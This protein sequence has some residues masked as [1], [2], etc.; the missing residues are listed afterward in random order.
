MTDVWS[1]G[2]NVTAMHPIG[3]RE[4]G[5]EAVKGSFEQVA[6]LASDGQI[7]AVDQFIL[8]I[9]EIVYELGSDTGQDGAGTD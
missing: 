5:C 6:Q 7:K 2:A 3:G 8:V 1:Q 4:A 9:R